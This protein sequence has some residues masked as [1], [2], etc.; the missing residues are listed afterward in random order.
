MALLS[1]DLGF[2]FEHAEKKMEETFNLKT[3]LQKIQEAKNDEEYM[4][5]FVIRP[6]EENIYKKKEIKVI[7]YLIHYINHKN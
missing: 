6:G 4:E 1:Q 7:Y 3:R 5:K 2:E